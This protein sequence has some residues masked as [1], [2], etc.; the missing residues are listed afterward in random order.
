MERDPSFSPDGSKVAF[1]WNRSHFDGFAISVRDV[2]GDDPPTAITSGTFEDWGPTWSPDGRR[3]AFR[4]RH[5]EDGIY[6]VSASGGSET[7]LTHIGRQDQETLPQMSWSR[8]GKWIAAPDRDAS[9][10]THINL[11]A[12]KSG[13]RR[14]LTANRHGIDHAPAFSPDGK[15]LAYASCR[16]GASSCDVYIIDLD[17]GLQARKQRQI[18]AQGLYLR[19]IAWAP[20]RHSIVY[21]AGRTKSANTSLYRVSADDPDIPVRIDLAGSDARHPTVSPRSDLL[22]YTKLNGWRLMMIN[23]FR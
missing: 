6:W 11:V 8:D 20:D 19:G 17:S 10:A 4:R 1:A 12:V 9:G 7:F 16:S 2:K 5:G 22:A 21:S 3:I 23:N 15:S 14:E 18:T 13:E